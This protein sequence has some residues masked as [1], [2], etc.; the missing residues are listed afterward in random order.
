MVIGHFVRAN[1]AMMAAMAQ[2]VIGLGESSDRAL[3]GGKAYVLSNLMRAGFNV[4][5]G[6]VITTTPPPMGQNFE[7]EILNAFDNLN[8]PWVA[9]RS[10]A[11]NEDGAVAA[12]AGQLDT[13]LNIDREHLLESIQKCQRSVHSKRAKAYAEQKNLGSGDVAVLVQQMVQSD[14]S[15]VAFS[16][17][18]VTQDTNQIVLE[19]AYG[20]GEGV[21]SGKITPDTYVVAKNSGEILERHISTQVQ[22]F[23]QRSDGG[24]SWQS[25][26]RHGSIQKLSDKQIH[27]LTA[28]VRKL[29]IF[30][31]F[32]V[33]VEWACEKQQLYIL[34]SRPITTLS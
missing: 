14:V 18:P 11:I 29:E 26:L 4:P 17:H 22:K 3:V 24:S 27:E 9:V 8:T 7:G 5:N 19:A 30:H 15:G 20:L 12:W 25:V 23:A 31:S 2:G 16:V 1:S 32:P 28:T 6:F 21:V 13:F 33:D 34:Q 10:S